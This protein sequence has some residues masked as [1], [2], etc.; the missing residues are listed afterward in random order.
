MV[1][2]AKPAGMTAA[3]NISLPSTCH[4]VQPVIAL[5]T[6]GSGQVFLLC[7]V[8]EKPMCSLQLARRPPSKRPP[9]D[10]PQGGSVVEF[11]PRKK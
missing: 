7:S 8:C 3:A 1:A 5:Y 10:T 2:M 9:G 6:E 4:G 11:R